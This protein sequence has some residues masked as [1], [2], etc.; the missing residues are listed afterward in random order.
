MKE[1]WKVVYT[2]KRGVSGWKAKLEQMG[3]EPPDEDSHWFIA[4]CLGDA[5]NEDFSGVDA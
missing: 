3:V 4:A 1:W 5:L 2:K